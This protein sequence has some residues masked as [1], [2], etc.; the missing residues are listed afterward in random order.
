MYQTNVID[1]LVLLIDLTFHYRLRIVVCI[2]F[3][4]LV[5]S[6][7]IVITPSKVQITMIRVSEIHYIL[8]ML[9]QVPIIL[10]LVLIFY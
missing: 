10:S 6:T 9:L 1:V 3:F 8:A 2:I 5:D 4:L 7:S